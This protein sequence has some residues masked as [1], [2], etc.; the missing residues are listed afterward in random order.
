MSELTLGA[1]PLPEVLADDLERDH[2]AQADVAGEVDLTHP[3]A[4]QRS[5]DA[6]RTQLGL[7][8]RALVYHQPG[9]RID[10]E[11]RLAP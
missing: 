6:V 3:S 9:S 8:T 4:R 2:P 5:D 11:A 1:G 10:R 7:R